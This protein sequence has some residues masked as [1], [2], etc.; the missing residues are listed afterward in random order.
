[1]A[2]LLIENGR[3]IDPA[4][5]LDRIGSVY[6]ADGKIAGLDPAPETI[7]PDVKRIDATGKIITPGLIDLHVHLREP[8]GEEDET[9]ETGTLAA[10]SGGFTSIACC[11]NTTPP[12]DTQASVELVRELAFR[13]NH[14]HVF[15]LCCISKNRE[16]SE[17]AELGI[18]FEA[19]AVG[20]TDDGAP[21]DDAELM[22][23]AM[24][25]SLMFDRPVMSHA[26]S[27]PLDKG[28]VMHEGLISTLLGLRGMPAAAEEVMVSRDVALA[29]ATGARL[30]IIR[31]SR[32]GTPSSARSRT[33][34]RHHPQK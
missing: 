11:P 4:N 27:S 32:I 23:R 24:E 8:G 12:L 7:A 18:L 34:P 28:G 26:E 19:G 21:V 25:Y 2:S 6:I 9:I 29:E 13:A 5:H 20:C 1:M 22:R 14:C 16:G 30:H 33:P 31:Y 3:I 17:L 15:P 10:L